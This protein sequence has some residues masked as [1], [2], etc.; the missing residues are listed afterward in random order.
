M[1]QGLKEKWDLFEKLSLQYR[2]IGDIFVVLLILVFFL[3]VAA[4]AYRI[5]HIDKE[6]VKEQLVKKSIEITPILRKEISLTLQDVIPVY[7]EK[8]KEKI[9][10][11]KPEFEEA[12]R[13]ENEKIIGEFRKTVVPKAEEK[14]DE[15]SREVVSV[16]L[17]EFPELMESENTEKMI[18]NL[19]DSLTLAFDDVFNKKLAN[20]DKIFTNLR[21]KLEKMYTSDLEIEEHLEMKLLAVT[22]QLAGKRIS[23]EVEALEETN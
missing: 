18:K 7:A 1:S 17:D 19:I 15:V 6:K 5:T 14:F 12:L 4:I 23:Q 2:R 20:T 21:T 8:F 11:K 22:F 13:K 16:F 10:V 9:T 3:Q